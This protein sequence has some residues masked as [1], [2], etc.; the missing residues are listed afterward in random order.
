MTSVPASVEAVSAPDS[1]DY[2]DSADCIGDC[3]VVDSEDVED[4]EKSHAEI[5]DH[6]Q[7]SECEAASLGSAIVFIASH[8][9]D[10]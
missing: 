3:V 5:Y 7:N 1:I 6:H 10:I 8:N 4:K 2:Q 9:F